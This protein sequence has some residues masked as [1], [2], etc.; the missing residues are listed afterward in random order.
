M[1]VLTKSNPSGEGIDTLGGY[2]QGFPPQM[3][4]FLDAIVAGRPLRD[5][6]SQGLGEVLFAKA[7]YKSLSS[8]QWE[9]TNPNTSWT[10]ENSTTA[11]FRSSN[12]QTDRGAVN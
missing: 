5:S 2:E 1:T 8:K 10:S 12:V 11:L 7:V 6:V 9:S 4:E 3:E